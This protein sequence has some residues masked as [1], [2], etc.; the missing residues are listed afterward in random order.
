MSDTVVLEYEMANGRRLTDINP[1]RPYELTTEDVDNL[2]G[3]AKRLADDFLIP[4][5]FSSYR[6][7]FRKAKDAA[8]TAIGTRNII[9]L[10]EK[11]FD[12]VEEFSSFRKYMQKIVDK[13][14]NLD[15]FKTIDSNRK[16]K[17]SGAIF[18]KPATKEVK[19]PVSELGSVFEEA[20]LGEEKVTVEDTDAN[21]VVSRLKGKTFKDLTNPSA[22]GGDYGGGD[23]SEGKEFRGR[24]QQL[25]DRRQEDPASIFDNIEETATKERDATKFERVFLGYEK[26][27]KK[28]YKYLDF[29]KSGNVARFIFRTSAFY[30]DVFQ[31]MGMDLDENFVK[32]GSRDDT[33]YNESPLESALERQLEP[34][35]DVGKTGSIMAYRVNYKDNKM[36]KFGD[37]DE[38][39]NYSPKPEQ[40]KEGMETAREELL[41]SKHLKDIGDLLIEHSGDFFTPKGDDFRISINDIIIEINFEGIQP[42]PEVY[43]SETKEDVKLLS[44]K[45]FLQT[46]GDESMKVLAVINGINAKREY[47]E[48]KIARL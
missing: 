21:R 24:L 8:D 37:F 36:H 32:T 1:N 34:K 29:S 33:K 14:K 25:G 26:D 48:N 47:L 43:Q 5:L 18:G 3:D 13:I 27:K 6:T 10:N 44:K 35:R 42:V 40:Q 45:Q 41:D 31:E 22:I 30:N 19:K 12:S 23:T 11:A 15:V 4:Y 28:A 2:K 17:S 38:Q 9:S 46:A 39:G 7:S 16:L 20:D